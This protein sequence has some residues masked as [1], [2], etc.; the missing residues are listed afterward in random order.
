MTRKGA[1]TTINESMRLTEQEIAKL[2]LVLK[3]ISFLELLRMDELDALIGALE[4]RQFR[5][6]EVIIKQGTRGDTF[7]IMGSG[8]VGVY[9]N[10][11]LTR[12]KVTTLGPEAF[13]GEMALI[14]SSP[15]NA[16]VIGEAD[17]ELYAVSRDNFS[18]ILLKN[19][20]IGT[21]I[22]QTAAFRKAQNKAQGQ[23][24]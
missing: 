7:F 24:N 15:R 8:T 14:D 12:K 18:H 22:R 11:F 20:R 13:F 16:T 3:R 21:L 23:G 4:K 9:K 6:G 2:R 1:T 17:G 5:A 10:A 19:P